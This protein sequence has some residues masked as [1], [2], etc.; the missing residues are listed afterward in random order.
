M[1]ALIAALILSLPTYASFSEIESITCD[2][3]NV[4]VKQ[5]DRFYFDAVR[6]IVGF[7]ETTEDDC[8]V[9]DFQETLLIHSATVQNTTIST[10]QAVN[11]IGRRSSCLAGEVTAYQG[12][13]F[14]TF[15]V[16]DNKVSL[17]NFDNCKAAVITLKK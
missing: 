14:R 17:V 6:A 4:E 12:P 8:R 9:V 13:E 5:G 11:Q 16:V 3:K 10:Y 15:T 1:K 7:G 2:G